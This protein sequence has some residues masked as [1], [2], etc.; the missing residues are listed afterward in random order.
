MAG[1]GGGET[2]GKYREER[3]VGSRQRVKMY[4]SCSLH[5]KQLIYLVKNVEQAARTN[6]IF[7]NNSLVRAKPSARIKRKFQGLQ[8]TFQ[9]LG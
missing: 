9:L 7:M 1:G 6:K 2:G 8:E 3:K 5:S 4:F